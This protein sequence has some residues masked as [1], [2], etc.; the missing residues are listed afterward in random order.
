MGSEF[1]CKILSGRQRE[2]RSQNTL[3]RRVIREIYEHG[4]VIECA[5]FLE[6]ITEEA[7]FVCGY[8]H[9]CEDRREWWPA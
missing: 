1:D 6:V 5:L 3:D 7:Q 8:A 4:H 2:S 9:G